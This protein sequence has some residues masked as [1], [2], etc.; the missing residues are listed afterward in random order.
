MK[1]MHPSRE[2]QLEL[3][4]NDVFILPQYFDGVSRTEVDL[5]PLDFSGGSNP[6]V[7]ANMNAVTGLSMMESMARYG[8]LGVLP[9][10]M[11]LDEVK[12]AIACVKKA[13][14]NFDS[15]L[16]VKANTPLSLLIN[17][18]TSSYGK[19]E[20]LI[21][22]KSCGII[23]VVDEQFKPIGIIPFANGVLENYSLN[24]KAVAQD[25]MQKDFAYISFVHDKWDTNSEL[26]SK[27]FKTES[28]YLMEEAGLD[29]L[30]ILDQKGKLLGT[31]TKEDAVRLSIFNPSL[32]AKGELLTA[33]AIGINNSA[34]ERAEELHN[35]GLDV[36]VIDTAHGHQRKMLETIR[37]VRKKLGEEITVVAGN[38]CTAEA[39]TDLIKAG[40]NIVK[41]NVGPGAMCTTRMQTGCGRPTFSAMLACSQAAKKAGGWVWADGGV[42]HPR[43]VALYL[44]AGA[45]RVMI[46]TSLAGTYESEA[47]LWKDKEGFFKQ[48]YGMASY[49]AVET[50][51]QNLDSFE[52]VKKSFFQEGI[53]TSKI[54]LKQNQDSVGKILNSFIAGLQSAFTYTGVTNCSDFTESVIVGVQTSSGYF[55]GTPH[56]K[57][58]K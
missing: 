11:P 15:P 47:E 50:R 18:S 33:A 16:V 27:L 32:N 58:Q 57:I 24:K 8:G 14:V 17:Q 43:D 13:P 46:G 9:Q 56:G 6:I 10:D 21:F 44:A 53:S 1:F 28:F 39:T 54:Y 36:L 2:S 3:S 20:G 55:E 25:I 7:A 37:A 49:K 19:F 40:A 41:V 23:H 35:N 45:S 5:T 26:N 4:L 38:V 42:K 29:A 12:K 51:N 31:L 22:K 30:T 52:K 48:N 34:V